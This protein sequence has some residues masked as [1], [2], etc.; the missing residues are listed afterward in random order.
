MTFFFFINFFNIETSDFRP[1]EETRKPGA[2][3]KA[4][5]EE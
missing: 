2:T 3:L 4:K 5:R 1:Q